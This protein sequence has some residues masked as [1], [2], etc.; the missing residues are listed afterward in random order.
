MQGKL[1]SADGRRH[2]AVP[3]CALSGHGATAHGR[4][5]VR[6]T[7]GLLA[8]ETAGPVTVFRDVPYARLPVGPLRFASPRPPVPWQGVLGT[9]R[10]SLASWQQPL[11]NRPSPAGGEDCLYAN[12]WTPGPGGSRP[13]LVYI[14]G[15]GRQTGAGSLPTYDGARLAE[16]GD[17]V[18]VT[19]NYRLGA[20]GFGLHEALADPETQEFATWGLQDQIARLHRVRDNAVSFGGDPGNITLSGT[21]AGGASAWQLALPPQVRDLGRRI[22][23]ITPSHVSAPATALTPAD[24]RTVYEAIARRLDTTV[25]GLRTVPAAALGAAWAGLFPG[26]PEERRVASGRWYRGPVV[27]GRTMPDLDHRLPTPAM[28]VLSVHTRT[29][30]A[31]STGPGSPQP[32]SAPDGPEALRRA[33]H[34]VLSLAAPDAT[35]DLVDACATACREAALIEVSP[36]DPL[37]LWTE[38]W[39]ELMFCH[40]IVRLAERH[41][42][43]GRHPLYA[44]EFAHPARAP[45]FGTPHEATS[46]SLF[47]THRL[48]GHTAVFGDGPV[49]R[50]LSDLLTDSVAAF[51]RTSVPH[52]PLVPARPEFRSCC[53]TPLRARGAWHPDRRRPG[54][55][56]GRPHAP[57]R[58]TEVPRRPE[59]DPWS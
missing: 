53:P 9:G 44:M 27:E 28:P 54:D 42:R 32:R 12:V 20:L 47:G 21:S 1:E 33:V 55:H 19:F 34:D 38:I 22:V 14:H 10:S 23:P 11:P 37:S 2:A 13:V 39:G 7:A 15:G 35:G 46:P 5:V 17:L 18:V 29:E 41:A 57:P 8:G 43:T 6:T 51:A 50:L 36:A 30:G 3:P 59:L 16:R 48:P 52:T 49:E 45:H 4:T 24:S 58:P 25:P 40:Q 56:R 26:A 31:F